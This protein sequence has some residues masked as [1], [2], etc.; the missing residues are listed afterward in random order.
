MSHLFLF[1]RPCVVLPGAA[2]N[3]AW[4]QD[5]TFP[6]CDIIN[7]FVTKVTLKANRVEPHILHVFHVSFISFSIPTRE[8]IPHVTAT[9]EEDI[10]TVDLV[11]SKRNTLDRCPVIRELPDAKLDR[12]A[13]PG[14]AVGGERNTQVI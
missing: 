9:A 7:L 14:L 8:H 2:T 5:D 12:F 1:R 3:E 11:A 4:H 6:V 13:I 10:L